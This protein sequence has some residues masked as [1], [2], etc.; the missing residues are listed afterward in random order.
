MIHEDFLNVDDN[1]LDF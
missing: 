1:V